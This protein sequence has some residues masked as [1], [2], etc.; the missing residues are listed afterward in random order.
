MSWLSDGLDW[1]GNQVSSGS[2]IGSSIGDF[3]SNNQGLIKAG[4]QAYGAWDAYNNRADTRNQL[5]DVYRQQA[6]AD[7]AYQEQYNQWAAQEAA[8]RNAA[9]RANEAA[10][11]AA[12]R[13]MAE[14]QKANL[15]QVEKD[16]APYRKSARKLIPAMTKDYQGF[17]NSTGLLNAYLTP[18]VMGDMKAGPQPAWTF[19]APQNFYSAA[20][21]TGSMDMS[22]IANA[23]EPKKGK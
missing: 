18:T 9:A 15:K 8:S 19:Q 14:A 11:A 5:L 12:A 20:P 16:M 4:R 22:A 23:F 10:R 6:E 2:N 7:M 3:I 17:L 21:V 13:Q 1:L